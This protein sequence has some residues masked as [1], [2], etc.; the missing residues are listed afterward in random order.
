MPL[1]EKLANACRFSKLDL[2]SGYHQTKM[3]E[4]DIYKIAFRTYHGHYGFLVKPFGLTNA[5]STFQAHMNNILQPYLR[6]FFLVFFDNILVYLVTWESHMIHL[7]KV[8][9]MLA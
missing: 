1:V 9:E 4:E 6:K 3:K 5:P 7:Y 8:F 2:Q